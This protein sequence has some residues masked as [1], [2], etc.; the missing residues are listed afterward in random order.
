MMRSFI[1]ATVLLA[2]AMPARAQERAVPPVV[3]MIS[4]T[5]TASRDVEPDRAILTV[6]VTTEKPNAADASSE[7]AKTASAIVD[8]IKAAGIEPKDIQTSA[9]SLS[10]TYS[11]GTQNAPSR[12]TGYRASNL[13][14]VRVRSLAGVGPLLQR[15][16]AKGI[17]N[18]SSPTFEVSNADAIVDELRGEA[19]KDARRKADLYVAALGV[20]LG[21]VLEIRSEGAPPQPMFRARAMAPA[22]MAAAPPPVEAG[23]QQLSTDVSVTFEISQ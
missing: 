23:T 8:E 4:V 5:G 1:L 22:P 7:N 11:P 9:L 6:G 20:K 17:T 3:P 2:A 12:I 21:R 14:T 19:A 16:A 13:V 10:P 18:L 15:L